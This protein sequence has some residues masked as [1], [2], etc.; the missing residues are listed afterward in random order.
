MSK[1]NKKMSIV[2]EKLID[3]SMEEY[4]F[5][6]LDIKN[7]QTTI[8]N[9]YFWVAAS[10]FSVYIAIFRGLFIDGDFIHL[11]FL[12]NFPIFLH[13][14]IVIIGFIPI[15]YVIFTGV[16]KMRGSGPG[17]MNIFGGAS[18]LTMY[19]AYLST[20]HLTQSDMIR[21][22]LDK[23]ARSVAHNASSCEIVGKHLRNT[24]YALLISIGSGLFAFLI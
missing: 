14:T 18:P 4:K 1:L 19:E 23:C 21:H 5:Y 12:P 17:H 9:I 22:L 13:R 2:A 20:P 15:I 8:Q 3:I 24:S 7:R 16:D 10:L 6:S 11:N